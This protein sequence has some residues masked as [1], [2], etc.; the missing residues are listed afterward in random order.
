MPQPDVQAPIRAMLFMLLSAAFLAASIFCGKLA[1]AGVFGPPVHPLQ[2]SH[3]RF[4]FAILALGVV[5]MAMRPSISAPNL[6]LHL[7]RSI[8][9]YLGG[10]CLFASVVW[11]PLADATAISFL[12]PIF[13]M[14]LAIPLLGERVGPWRWVAAFI[15]F[16]GAMVLIRPFTDGFQ[17]LAFVALCGAMLFGVEITLIKKI[18]RA[19]RPFQILIINN[20]I[21]AIVASIVV[22]WVWVWPVPGQWAVLV[23]V[24]LFMV[25]GQFF[26]IQAM[27]RADASLVAPISNA[28]LIF[29]VIYDFLVLGVAP[30]W[31]SWLG[32][33]FIVSGAVLIAWREGRAK[34]A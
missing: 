26:F 34:H 13:A 1:G 12:N 20:S 4:V 33:G 23:G 14:M 2:V 9:G 6:P 7:L 11:I 16:V 31:V 30:A 5:A 8:C 27:Q 15:G 3:A 10:V 21:G 22:L 32:A 29:A 19:E 18:T 24:G 17:P 25:T 28:V